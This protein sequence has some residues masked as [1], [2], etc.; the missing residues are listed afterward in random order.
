MSNDIPDVLMPGIWPGAGLKAYK[1]GSNVTVYTLWHQDGTTVDNR[2]TMDA[3]TAVCTD[4]L[5]DF[6]YDPT[7]G[8]TVY[9]IDGSRLAYTGADGKCWTGP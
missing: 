8:V 1:D 6:G 7:I 2:T 3:A 4:T 9:A 5:G